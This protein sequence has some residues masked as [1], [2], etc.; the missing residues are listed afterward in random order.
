MV[1][2][3]WTSVGKL[4]TEAMWTPEDAEVY[5]RLVEENHRLSYRTAER[6][7]LSAEE[8]TANRNRVQ[9]NLESMIDKLEY[10]KSMPAAWSRYLLWTGTVLAVLGAAFHYFGRVRV[11]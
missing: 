4:A 1:V 9:G 7:G 11:S 5:S 8:F 2:I 10:A 6:S 3:S